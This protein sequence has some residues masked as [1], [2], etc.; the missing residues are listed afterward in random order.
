MFSIYTLVLDSDSDYKLQYLA[1]ECN[2]NFFRIKESALLK[3]YALH[4]SRISNADSDTKKEIVQQLCHVEQL[5]IDNST[6]LRK[7][8]IHFVKSFSDYLN[9]CNGMNK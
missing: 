9:F 1:A 4:K 2:L 3:L 6:E 5:L 7:A 8:K